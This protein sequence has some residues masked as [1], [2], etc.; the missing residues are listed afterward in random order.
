MSSRCINPGTSNAGT[1]ISA[2][3][4]AGP[5]RAGMAA[6]YPSA[7]GS[8]SRSVV[9]S[10]SSVMTFERISGSSLQAGSTWMDQTAAA[11][12]PLPNDSWPHGWAHA[13]RGG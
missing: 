7:C 10:F 4:H 1:Y 2:Q 6:P 12:C 3:A 9:T 8:P 13:S 11:Q 5:C